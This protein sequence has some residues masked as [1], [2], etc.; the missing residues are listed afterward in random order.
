MSDGD[1]SVNKEKDMGMTRGSG[2]NAAAALLR[3]YGHDTCYGAKCANLPSADSFWDPLIL[4]LCA[5]DFRP[6]PATE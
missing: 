2:G 1:K 6:L 5:F 3:A 4:C